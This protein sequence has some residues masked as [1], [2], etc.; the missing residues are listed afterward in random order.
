MW[1]YLLAPEFCTWIWRIIKDSAIPSIAEWGVKKCLDWLFGYYS[2]TVNVKV[3]ISIEN[4]AKAGDNDAKTCIKRTQDIENSL[5]HL[6][7]ENANYIVEQAE[8]GNIY[9]Q[10]LLGRMYLIGQGRPQNTEQAIF[11]FEKSAKQG[12]SRAQCNLG[13]IYFEAENYSQ[14]KEWFEQSASRGNSLAQY[15][16]GRI[17]YKGLGVAANPFKAK[18]WFEKS[19]KMERPRSQTNLGIMYFRGE[20]V[21]QNYSQAREWFEKAAAQKN[22]LAQYYL[23][24]IYQEGLGVD[25]EPDQAKRWCRSIQ[26][27]ADNGDANALY[28]AGLMYDKGLVVARDPD[29]AKSCWQSSAGKG[30]VEAQRR[31]QQHN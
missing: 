28:Y 22:F 12:S 1:S 29:K 16:L 14:A 13:I 24:R 6:S 30:N 19:A 25:I 7:A 3:S 5:D 8:Q 4:K 23:V 31:L 10:Y 11:W 27:S 20:G 26:E 9:A 17:Y 2:K 15:Y 18:G 21:I